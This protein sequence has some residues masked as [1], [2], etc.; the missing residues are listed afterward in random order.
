MIA[1]N[2]DVD[3][4]VSH[5]VGQIWQP[6]INHKFLEYKNEDLPFASI[7]SNNEQLIVMA[8]LGYSDSES[9]RKMV[10]HLSR[11]RATGTK[12]LFFD[13]HNWPEKVSAEAFDEYFH[14]N[15]ISSAEL[16]ANE[17]TPNNNI[18]LYLSR[19]AT[20]DDYNIPDKDT[21]DL[22]DIVNSNYPKLE[23]ISELVK[24]K[25]AELKLSTNALV[26]LD[27]YRTKRTEA[28]K[29]LE[30]SYQTHETKLGRFVTGLASSFLYMKPGHR[31]IRDDNRDS[32]VICF[33]Q[34]YQN[35]T[36]KTQ[37]PDQMDKLLSLFKGDGRGTEGGF[38]PGVSVTSNNYEITKDH[39]INTINTFTE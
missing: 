4:L 10:K 19:L 38:D 1:P 31:K 25:K 7:P 30:D 6:K 34:D 35:C 37:T 22:C 36:F 33:Y 12:V 14:S 27:Q 28:F 17:L 2:H 21:E 26:S 29:S 5:V 18:A 11:L 3:S 32:N 15:Q 39:I 9:N 23:L 8:D 13:Q 24:L 16:M 20:K